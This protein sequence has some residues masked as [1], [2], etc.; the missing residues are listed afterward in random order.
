MKGA[1]QTFIDSLAKKKAL[2]PLYRQTPLIV[3]LNCTDEQLWM[4]ISNE[5]HILLDQKP[6]EEST[7]V[8]SGENTIL[9]QALKGERPLM[10]LKEEGAIS[11]QGL[12][13]H[14]L[15]LESLLILSS[16]DS[17]LVI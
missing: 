10:K 2:S 11:V 13:N 5:G 6:D 1:S 15:T 9:E 3:E 12:F 17:F 7:L 4:K 14:Q 8:I 16:K